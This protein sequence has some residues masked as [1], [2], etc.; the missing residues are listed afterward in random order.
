MLVVDDRRVMPFAARY[1]RTSARAIHMLGRSGHLQQLWLDHDLGGDDTG[2]AVADWMAE[3]AFLG[4]PLDVEC[5]F[6]HSANG[7]GAQRLVLTLQRWYPHVHQTTAPVWSSRRARVRRA[8][9]RVE[10]RWDR[11]RSR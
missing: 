1:A 3:Q 10:H 9:A 2:M 4:H 5:I 8:W 6:V 11:V 7:P